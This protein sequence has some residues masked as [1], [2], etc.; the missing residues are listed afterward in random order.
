MTKGPPV[1]ADRRWWHVVTASVRGASHVRAHLPNQDAVHWTANRSR[2][3][4]M[5]VADGHGSAESFRS[6]VGSR[7]AVTTAA[8]VLLSF[9]AGEEPDV[10]AD[11]VASA[12]PAALV[13]A[14]T[15]AVEDHLEDHPFGPDDPVA[16]L[17]GN[18]FLAYGSTLL[19][20]VVVP[21]RIVLLQLGDGDFLLHRRRREGAE[22][23]GAQRRRIASGRVVLGDTG[24]D[25]L[26]R[27]HVR[28][29]GEEAAIALGAFLRFGFRLRFEDPGLACTGCAHCITH[30][31]EGIIRFRP[32]PERGLLVTGVD[33]SS[34][35]KLCGE[36][37]AVCPEKLFKEMPYEDV[38]EEMEVTT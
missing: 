24:G 7:L 6:D 28:A 15:A 2:L 21:G 19:A 3:T 10:L 13:A 14:W 32:D 11:R 22:L 9:D 1:D 37:I 18:P 5:A 17:G 29:P 33:V 38:W 16:Q 20:A 26:A 34:Y 4:V 36:C 25:R 12:G 8:E 27:H 30:C 23:L 31:P 35:C